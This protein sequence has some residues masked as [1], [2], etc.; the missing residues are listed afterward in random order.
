MEEEG[1]GVEGS[2][3]DPFLPTSAFLDCSQTVEVLYEYLDG[4]LTEERRVQIRRH[5]DLCGP[6]VGAFGFEEDLRKVIA[7]RCR[8][9]VPDSLIK[10]VDA[11][12]QAERLAERGAGKP[13]GT[14]T[15]TQA[16]TQSGHQGGS[17][18]G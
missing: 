18:S 12:L 13:A 15:G 16:G 7:S 1:A 8:D 14:P 5:L 11:A 10:R 2:A 6:C 17:T 9:R 4:E 3:P